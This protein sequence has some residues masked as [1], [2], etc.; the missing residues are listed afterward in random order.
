MMISKKADI[1]IATVVA[2]TLGLIVLFTMIYIFSQ[3]SDG[4]GDSSACPASGGRCV[5]EGKCDTTN[6][7][8]AS[9]GDESLCQGSNRPDCCPIGY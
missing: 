5:E 4:W 2:I 1:S 8:E 7:I 9:D 3:S 6:L